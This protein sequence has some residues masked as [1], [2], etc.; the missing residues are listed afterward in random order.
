MAGARKVT[1]TWQSA[2][3]TQTDGITPLCIRIAGALYELSWRGGYDRRKWCFRCG[4]R[5][6]VARRMPVVL[7]LDERRFQTNRHRCH[8]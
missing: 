1:V 2:M 4:A 7:P 5:Q 3:A 6:R 8:L